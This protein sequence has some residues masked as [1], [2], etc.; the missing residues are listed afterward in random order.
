MGRIFGGGASG[1]DEVI[2]V[3]IHAL[4]KETA[5]SSTDN[6]RLQENNYL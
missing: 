3:E 4:T 2:K 5:S 6:M 1:N